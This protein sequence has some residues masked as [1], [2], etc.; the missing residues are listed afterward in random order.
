MRLRHQLSSAPISFSRVEVRHHISIAKIKLVLEDNYVHFIAMSFFFLSAM[1]VHAC[2]SY[3]NG[4]SGT[5]WDSA[6]GGHKKVKPADCCN[7]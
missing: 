2:Q 5:F 7:K 3:S 1:L 6:Q 4:Q